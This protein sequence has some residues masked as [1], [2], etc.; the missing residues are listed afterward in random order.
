MDGGEY[1]GVESMYANMEWRFPIWY[2]FFVL[3]WVNQYVF[4][5]SFLLWVLQTLF[6][7]CL[8]TGIFCYIHFSCHILLQNCSVSIVIRLLVCL[9]ATSSYVLIQFFKSCFVS[10]LLPWFDIFLIHLLPPVFS[11][12]FPRI[13]IIITIIITKVIWH[14]KLEY[15]K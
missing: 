14:R 9:H 15:D 3:F 1:F 10:I 11:G 8:S 4:Y 5:L 13:I 12:F 6:P 7:C 2:F